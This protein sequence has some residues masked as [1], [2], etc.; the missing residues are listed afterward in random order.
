MKKVQLESGKIKRKTAAVKV[1]PAP[2]VRGELDL[3]GKRADE[4]EVALDGYLNDAALS[5]RNE[6]VIIHGIAT[7]TVRQIVRDLLTVHPLVRNFRSGVQGEGG[8]GVTVV[9][10]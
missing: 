5:N 10:L 9:S 2:S 3:R 7:G 8:E 6:V 1:P 4:V